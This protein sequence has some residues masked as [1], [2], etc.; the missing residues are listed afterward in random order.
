MLLIFSILVST[1]I[2]FTHK[3]TANAIYDDVASQW[4]DTCGGGGKLSHICSVDFNWTKLAVWW[5]T[6]HTYKN[7]ITNELF[8]LTSSRGFQLTGDQKFMDNARKV[9]KH[10]LSTI[11]LLTLLHGRPGHGV[12]GTFSISEHCF[13]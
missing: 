4:D 1:T 2:T 11:T 7:A 3:N 8:L 6:D 10:L 5:T 9:L 12:C 13:N